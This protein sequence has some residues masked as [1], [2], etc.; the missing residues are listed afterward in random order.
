MALKRK[1]AYTASAASKRARRALYPSRR[2]TAA[3]TVTKL[4]RLIRAR[5]LK[6]SKAQLPA[7]SAG[8]SANIFLGTP[9]VYAIG[10][11]G[12]GDDS[13]TRDGK[14]ISLKDLTV[15]FTLSGVNG[16]TSRVL[17]LIHKKPGGGGSALTFTEVIDTGTNGTLTNN[18]FNYNKKAQYRIL[19]DRT[20]IHNAN[21]LVHVVDFK[22]ELNELLQ[23]Y[24]GSGATI[25]SVEENLPYIMV[26]NSGA[27]GNGGVVQNVS[28]HMVRFFDS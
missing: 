28:T 22:Y 24:N 17:I 2:P 1:S 26:G 23:Q 5:E 12:Q 10:M 3:T 8:T 4:N 13:N 25:A 16:T 21:S 18:T 7:P 6:W 14:Q 19:F 15:K 11:V 9:A 20:Y 27:T